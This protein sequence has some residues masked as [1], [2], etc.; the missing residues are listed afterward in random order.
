M[1]QTS[2]EKYR[3]S[4]LTHLEMYSCTKYLS[5]YVHRRIRSGNSNGHLSK[6]GNEGYTI[7]AWA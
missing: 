4:G 3:L 1:A 5:K 7:G 2:M 6:K